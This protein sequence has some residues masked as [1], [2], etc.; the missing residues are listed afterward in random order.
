M[1]AVRKHDFC[2]DHGRRE[3][4]GL[5]FLKWLARELATLIALSKK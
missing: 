1:R 3:E 2:F 4:S 5:T